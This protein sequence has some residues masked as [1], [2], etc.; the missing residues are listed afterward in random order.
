[1]L[2]AFLSVFV[3]Q[4]VSLHAEEFSP[5]MLP[6]LKKLESEGL[7]G[8]AVLNNGKTRQIRVENVT[9]DSVEVIEVYGAL[10]RRI[11]SYS[12]GGFKSIRVLGNQRI[13]LRSTLIGNSKSKTFALGSEMIFPG[14]GYLYLGD[15]KQA[16]SLFTFTGV[17]LMT[18]V[19]TG[20][21]ATAGWLP[22]LSWVKIASMFQLNDKINA[23]NKNSIQWDAGLA[24]WSGSDGLMAKIRMPLNL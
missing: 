18:A 19:L 10:Q 14:A 7:W 11:V 16:L 6:I 21:D 8:E 23:M 5:P 3:F 12:V 20:E 15:K 24:T 22:L 1:M 13:Q 9:N 4:C 2:R 17:A